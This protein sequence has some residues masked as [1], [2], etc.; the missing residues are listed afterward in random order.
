MNLNKFSMAGYLANARKSL[1]E[2]NGRLTAEEAKDASRAIDEMESAM[3][4][5]DPEALIA[6]S[7]RLRAITNKKK[8][9]KEKQKKKGW[10]RGL[11]G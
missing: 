9:K 4:R 10:L 8:P 2:G 6:A 5:K 11:R 7:D 1:A 3:S